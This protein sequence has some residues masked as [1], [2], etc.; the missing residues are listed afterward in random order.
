MSDWNNFYDLMNLRDPH[1]KGSLEQ[2]V[3]VAG[4]AFRAFPSSFQSNLARAF[5]SGAN[6]VENNGSVGRM[7]RIS[8]DGENKPHR[9]CDQMEASLSEQG[10]SNHLPESTVS[11][12]ALARTA[13][14]CMKHVGM[15]MTHDRELPVADRLP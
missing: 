1:L 5:I 12:T 10:P 14:C 6:V 3:A 7:S 15:G 9:N 11:A 8:K 2:G 4:Q 13:A